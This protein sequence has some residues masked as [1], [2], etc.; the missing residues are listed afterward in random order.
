MNILYK[1]LKY[2]IRR[3]RICIY[4]REIVKFCDLMNALMIF[5]KYIIVQKIKG[6]FEIPMSGALK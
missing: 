1:V 4:F 3:F 6:I 5:A 2:V